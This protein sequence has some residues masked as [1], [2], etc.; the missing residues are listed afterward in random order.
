VIGQYKANIAYRETLEQNLPVA[1]A[2]GSGF[3][4]FS[5][6]AQGLLTNRYLNG[7]PTGSRASKNVFLRPEQ[8]TAEAIANAQRLGAIAAERGQSL[9]Q[10]AIAWLLA[11]NVTSVIVGASSVAQLEDNINAIHNITFSED[12]LRAIESIQWA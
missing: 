8:V 6:L 5:P 10:M 3:I 9:A 7:I 4:C 2:N 11:K 1:Q 12:E